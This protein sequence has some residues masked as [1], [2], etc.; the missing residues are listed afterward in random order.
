MREVF[1]VIEDQLAGR[2]GPSR[3]PWSLEE[4][5]EA[6]LD[7][8]LNLSEYAPNEDSMALVGFESSWIPLPTTVPPDQEAERICLEQ[9]SKAYNFIRD[10]ITKGH[11]VLVHCVAG[12]DRT[13]L[14]LTYY[15]AKSNSLKV[16]EAINQVRRVQRMAL[17][18]DGWEDM[19]VRVI[20][21]LLGVP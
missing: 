12:C 10:K 7:A 4:L 11:R 3:E 15:L 19:A 20:S 8:I 9:A 6:G 16:G 1:W 21:R 2:P 17:S 13:G 5:R 18:A 14:I